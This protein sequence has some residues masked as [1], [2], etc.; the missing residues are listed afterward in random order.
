MTNG[1]GERVSSTCEKLRAE[2]ESKMLEVKH[3]DDAVTKCE[4]LEGIVLGTCGAILDMI[5]RLSRRIPRRPWIVN[6]VGGVSFLTVVGL[7]WAAGARLA[8]MDSRDAR[9]EER[10]KALAAE[11]SAACG[12]AEKA[13]VQVNRVERRMA[14]IDGNIEVLMRAR[15]LRPLPA[16]PDSDG[17]DTM[18]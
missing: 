10:D 11:V 13:A 7:A 18:P 3:E 15:G 1:N 17:L 5:A 6:V 8:H 4:K 2:M 16:V 9:L 14:R 12:E